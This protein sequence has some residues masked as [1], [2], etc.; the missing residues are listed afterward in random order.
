MTLSAKELSEKSGTSIR[1]I[2]Y[3]TTAGILKTEGPQQ[4]GTG[5]PLEYN[6]DCIDRVALMGVIS[7]LFQGCPT[8]ILEK[9]YNHYEDGYVTFDGIDISWGT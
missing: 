7:R 1:N 4:P 2:H 9:V 5:F 8:E 6:E 3:W